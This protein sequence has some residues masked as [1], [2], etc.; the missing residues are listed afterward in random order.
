MSKSHN[1]RPKETQDSQPIDFRT[2]YYTLRERLWIVA[3]CLL[4]T[5]EVT[6]HQG[7]DDGHLPDEYLP[8]GPIDGDH[9]TLGDDHHRLQSPGA[10]AG[11][12]LE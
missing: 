1:T 3:L 11:L 5:L 8:R 10:G 6:H 12:L 9:V 4:I 2:L 7:V